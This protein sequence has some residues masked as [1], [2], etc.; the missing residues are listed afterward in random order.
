MTKHLMNVD[1][2]SVDTEENWLAEMPNWEEGDA[3]QGC[4]KSREDQFAALVEVVKSGEGDWVE[5]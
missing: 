4:F 1:T 5:A 3:E 2:G